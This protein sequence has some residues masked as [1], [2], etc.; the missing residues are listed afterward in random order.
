[1]AKKLLGPWKVLYPVRFYSGGDTTSQAFGKH[2]QEI[3]R[4][5]G[6]LNALDAGKAGSAEIADALQKHID[7][8][9]PHPNWKPK[10]S[11][12]DLTGDIPASKIVGDLTQAYIDISRV[13]GDIPA[14]RVKGTLSNAYIDASHVTG[15][16]ELIQ[17]LVKNIVPEPPEPVDPYPVGSIVQ[18]GSLPFTVPPGGKWECYCYAI[19]ERNKDG[20]VLPDEVINKTVT[21]N[22]GTTLYWSTFGSTGP[23]TSGKTEKTLKH[24]TLT[25]TRIE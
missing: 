12:S 2:I 17:E 19:L 25:C 6:L 23:G 21:K 15:L 8:A 3:E 11:A 7:S 16:R 13:R 20:D 18:S 24:L 10:I 4:I 14:E 5:Y 9:N 22:G 1:M